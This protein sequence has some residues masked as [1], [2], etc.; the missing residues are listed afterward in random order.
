MDTTLLQP[1]AGQS[2]GNKLDQER[3]PGSSALVIPLDHGWSIATDP[4]DTGRAEA[5]FRARQPGTEAT[6]VP[7]IIQETFPGYHGVVWYWL[8]FQPEPHPYAA[9]RYLLRFHAVDYLADVWLNSIYLGS[10]EGGETPFVLDATHAVRPGQDNLLAVR[11][12]NPGDQPIDGIVLDETPHRNKTVQYMSGVLPDY[13]GIIEPVE[14]LL[15]PAIRIAGLYLQPDWKTGRVRIQAT[16]QNAFSKT[17][18]A[19]V[20][21]AVTRTTMGEPLLKDVAGFEVPPGDSGID[22][23]LQIQ[24]HRLWELDDPCLYRLNLNLQATH[25]DGSDETSCCFGFR[26]FRVVNGYFRLNGRRLLLRSTHTGNHVPFGQVVPPE[27]YP[28]LLRRDLLYAKAS[29]FNTIRFIDCLAH[30]YQLDMCDEMGLMVYEESPASWELK[31]SQWMKA[32]YENT[33]RETILRDRNHP[34]VVIWGMLNETNDGPVFREAVSAL[35]LVRSLDQTRLVLLSSGRW[36]EDLGIGSV[37]N[38]GSSEWEFTW[39]K[40]AAGAGH[41]DRHTPGC[42]DFHYYPPAPQPP[43]SVRMMRTL[44]HN[45][46]PVF[47]SECGVGSMMDVIHEARMYEEA[48]I[49]KDAEDYVFIRSMADRFIADWSRYG[50]DT[51][52][53]Y[54]ETLLRVSQL[55]MALHRLFEFNI[56]RSNPRICGFNLTG[57]LDHG[58]TGEGVWRFWRDWKPGAF[59]AMRDGWAPVRWCLFVEPTHTYLGRPVTLEAVL[60]NEDVVRPGQYPAQFR[61]WGPNG[62]AWEREAAVLIPATAPGEDG[63][64]AM[65]VL[66]EDV[67]L[68]DSAGTYEFVPFIPHGIAPPETSW[69]FYLSDPK[70]LPHVSQS[71]ITWHMPANVEAW[72]TGHGITITPMGNG[73]SG[74]PEVIL[75]G[76]VSKNPATASEWKELAAHM[77]TGSTVVFLAPQA[78]QRDH[79]AA[80]WLPLANKGRVYDFVDWLYHKEC[81][82]K[83]HPVFAG[84]QG[85]GILD[86][87]YYG[88]V[89]PHYLF[90]GQDTPPE[91]IVTA[92]AAGYWPGNYHSGVLLGSYKFAAGQFFINTFVLLDNIDKHPAADRM[93]L[94]L[95]EYAAASVTGPA[96]PLPADFSA[97]LKEIGYA[98]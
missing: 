95:I 20:R 85:K 60:A 38:P 70:S 68:R 91:V 74:T 86:W 30:P 27:N 16:V 93:L 19:R 40:E 39:G 26:D 21:F 59:D 56:I 46:K 57:M 88:P 11:V 66:K 55:K 65:E 37:S 15:T 77:A 4:H 8:E 7:S 90:E 9:G 58:M 82:A 78:F 10:H 33:V 34:S 43:E 79:E 84:L 29:G 50:M 64:L 94:N 22:H 1:A 12:L 48:G 44:G 23:E 72:L 31:N 47:L 71:V 53:P 5:W 63:P 49:R 3:T 89:L 24:D 25:M 6:R 97:R 32:R 62:I 45:S 61:L 52:Y 13:G 18:S 42:G 69:Q 28:D 92:F 17:S 83:P 51:A 41:L 67:V 36:D 81:V 80:A 54:P 14:L 96:A 76:D 98:N 35:P 87:G 75:V 73:L 2:R